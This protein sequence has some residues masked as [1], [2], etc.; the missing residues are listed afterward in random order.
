MMAVGAARALDKEYRLFDLTDWLRL[1]PNREAQTLGGVS[2]RI[3]VPQVVVCERYTRLPPV[4]VRFSRH[5]VFVRDNWTC[6]YCGRQLPRRMLNL[7]H[8]LPR[9]KGGKTGWENVV[10][11]CLPCNMKKG[12]KLPNEAGMRLLQ[13]PSQPRWLQWAAR[14][15]SLP[16]Y[17]QWL[18]FIE[19]GAH[20][21][22]EVEAL[23]QDCWH[24]PTTRC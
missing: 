13:I 19:R 15:A 23:A 10:A 3:L 16:G 21:S 20:T 11:C 1:I 7:D 18:P 14:P 17:Q 6:Q 9:S 4:R 5:N 24:A 2:S 22:C 8:V 12:D